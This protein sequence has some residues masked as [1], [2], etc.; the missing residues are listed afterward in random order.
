MLQTPLSGL[1]SLC[2]IGFGDVVFSFSLVSLYFLIFSLISLLSHLL[3]N[4]MLFSFRVFKSF[5]G[6]FLI[7]LCFNGCLNSVTD[8]G[9]VVSIKKY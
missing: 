1:L 9:Q 6:F 4:I 5:E 8:F 3:F 2:L 7:K